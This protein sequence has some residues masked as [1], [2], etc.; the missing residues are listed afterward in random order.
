MSATCRKRLTHSYDFMASCMSLGKQT[1]MSDVI[2]VRV[3][4]AQ[5]RKRVA[6]RGYARARRAVGGFACKPASAHSH[7]YAMLCIAAT[8]H[9]S[10]LCGTRNFTETPQVCL[11]PSL[12]APLKPFSVGFCVGRSPFPC[13]LDA[14]AMQGI[15]RAGGWRW[16]CLHGPAQSPACRPP[17]AARR[18]SGFRG[19]A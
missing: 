19:R 8:R 13:P 17:T 7:A 16:P 18:D 3:R 15:A 1:A 11:I 14:A 5:P 2:K 4:Y 9:G 6:A 12:K 10:P